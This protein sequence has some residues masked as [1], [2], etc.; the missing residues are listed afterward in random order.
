MIKVP[1]TIS[2]MALIIITS[3]FTDISRPLIIF[4]YYE[5]LKNEIASLMPSLI[6]R[7]SVVEF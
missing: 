3:I 2:Y 1:Y 5:S 4:R 7:I 6:E